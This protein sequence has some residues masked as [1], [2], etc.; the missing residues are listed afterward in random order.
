MIICLFLKWSVFHHTKI[1]TWYV[2]IWR[3]IAVCFNN[4]LLEISCATREGKLFLFLLPFGTD[5]T[6][7]CWLLVP[8]WSCHCPIITNEMTQHIFHTIFSLYFLCSS[9]IDSQCLAHE[10]MHCSAYKSQCFTVGNPSLPAIELTPSAVSHSLRMSSCHFA[11]SSRMTLPIKILELTPNTSSCLI[12][13]SLRGSL[14]LHLT[15][16]SDQGDF[17]VLYAISER[18]DEAAESALVTRCIGEPRCLNHSRE[19]SQS[20]WDSTLLKVK[21]WDSEV[22]PLERN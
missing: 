18:P 3:P 10:S 4:W 22:Q 17:L 15:P 1:L 6:C 14:K 19:D 21:V 16:N 8:H 11:G 5:P 20:L 2:Y 12:L 13:N 7:D 9:F